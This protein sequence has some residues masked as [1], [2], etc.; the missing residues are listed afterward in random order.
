MLFSQHIKFQ[1]EGFQLQM[2]RVS[3]DQS[4]TEQSKHTE[5]SLNRAQH[6]VNVC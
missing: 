3:D 1:N 2:V 6:E 4:Q 5:Q